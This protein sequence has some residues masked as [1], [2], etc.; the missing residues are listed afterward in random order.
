[1]NGQMDRLKI[2]VR[3]SDLQLAVENIEGRCRGAKKRQWKLTLVEG[4]NE[5]ESSDGRVRDVKAGKKVKL[6]KD[7]GYESDGTQ[8]AGTSTRKKSR[9]LRASSRK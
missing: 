9:E 7:D 6:M 8:M 3:A 1:M 2:T 4:D 5:Q